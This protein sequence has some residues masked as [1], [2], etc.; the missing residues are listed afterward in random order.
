MKPKNTKE[1]YVINIDKWLPTM[2]KLVLG[3]TILSKI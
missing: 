3:L 2:Q 1:N